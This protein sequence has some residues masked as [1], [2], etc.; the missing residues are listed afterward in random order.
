[1]RGDGR[2]RLNRIGLRGAEVV[3][4]VAFEVQHLVGI[5]AAVAQLADDFHRNGTEVLANH[6]AAVTL[7]FQRQ[8][9]QQVIDRVFHVGAVNGG[10]TVRDPP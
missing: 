7:T 6:H 8:H 5:N 10:F 9:R 1:M 3:L 4:A 2:H